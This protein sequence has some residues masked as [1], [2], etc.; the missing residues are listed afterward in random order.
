M[1]GFELAMQEHIY[2]ESPNL[3]CNNIPLDLI[4]QLG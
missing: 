4:A 3:D 1:T 2:F